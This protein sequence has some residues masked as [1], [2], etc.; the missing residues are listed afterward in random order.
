M[1]MKKYKVRQDRFEGVWYVMKKVL[2]QNSQW[3]WIIIETHKTQEE[4]Q[5]ARRRLSNE[6]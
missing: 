5:L 6:E 3:Q 4:A 1:A 2:N